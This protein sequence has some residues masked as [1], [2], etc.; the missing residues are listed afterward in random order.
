MQGR[1]ARVRVVAVVSELQ[2]SE[3]ERLLGRRQANNDHTMA[4]PHTA[5]DPPTT[6]FSFSF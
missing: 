2:T 3:G 4:A 1:H 5:P 6:I